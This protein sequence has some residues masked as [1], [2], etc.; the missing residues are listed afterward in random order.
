MSDRGARVLAWSMWALGIAFTA[1]GLAL[2]VASFGIA[3]PESW[4]FRGFTA[5]FAVVFGTLGALLVAARR[6]RIGWLLLGAGLLSGIQCFAEE[7]AIYG[8]V[9]R[10]G[11][12]PGAAYL[13]WLNSWIW[14]P[15]L[16]LVGVFVPLL[17][18]NGRFLSPRSRA[19]GIATVA[20]SLFLAACLGVTD[21]PLNNAPFVT[22]PFGVA[23]FKGIDVVTGT[24]YPP[25]LIGY[26]G[27]VACALGAIAS[28]AVRFRAARGV[29]RQQMK[30]LAFGGGILVLGFIAGA[31]LQQLG[32][33]GQISFIVTLQIVPISV[34][35]A[36]LRY[37]LYDIDVLINRALVYGATTA[38]IAASFFV[39]IV[40]LQTPLRSVNGGSELAVAGST[41]LCF[42]LFQPLRRRFQAAID[43]RFYRSRYDAVRTLDLFTRRLASEVDLAAVRMDLAEALEATVQPAHMSVWLRDVPSGP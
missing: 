13:G 29:E 20:V 10:P 26:G 25:F 37:R 3:L 31:G 23:G 40:I 41:L 17:F 1:A 35:I 4:G 5:L 15:I 28:V 9:A 22:N 6:S 34:A 33:I 21:G 32:K 24:P 27:L 11:S 43:R 16:A 42:A 2:L 8:I 38:A 19:V 14:V 30:F 12:L 18:P 36:V 39:L 7:Y